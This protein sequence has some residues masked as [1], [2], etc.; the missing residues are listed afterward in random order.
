[1]FF[2]FAVTAAHV[3]EQFS[4]G[5]RDPPRAEL[6]DRN[7]GFD[8]EERLIASGKHLGIDIATFR[9]TPEE[10]AE[11]R[12]RVLRGTDGAWPLRRMWARWSTSA[13]SRAATGF[14]SCEV[15]VCRRSGTSSEASRAAPCS[16]QSIRTG[17]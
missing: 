15:W 12:K 11:T 14:R 10:I 16:S 6:P 5:S 3:F 17:S 1:M 8:P 7:I 9:V 2:P 4:E 13:A